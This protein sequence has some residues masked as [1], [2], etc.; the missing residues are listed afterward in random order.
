[1]KEAPCLHLIGPMKSQ[2]QPRAIS[3]DVE[4]TINLRR[5]GGCRSRFVATFGFTVTGQDT[6]FKR[7]VSSRNIEETRYENWRYDAN[8]WPQRVSFVMWSKCRNNPRNL[9]PKF[10]GRRVRL[11]S[12]VDTPVPHI[13]S[14]RFGILCVRFG[15]RIWSTCA[16]ASSDMDSFLRC[17]PT[18]GTRMQEDECTAESSRFKMKCCS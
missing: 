5:H 9:V 10:D 8:L 17:D 14:L 16:D 1:M 15:R 2:R 12:K 7:R 13:N 18:G 4:E 11:E 3:L 6:S